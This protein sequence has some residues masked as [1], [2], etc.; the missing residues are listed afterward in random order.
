MGLLR[1]H[2][3]HFGPD[4][5][6]TAR[7]FLR[8]LDEFCQRNAIEGYRHWVT[9]HPLHSVST[10]ECDEKHLAIIRDPLRPK[11]AERVLDGPAT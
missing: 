4:A 6:E 7:H 2:W 9:E 10:L 1:F 3:D 8:H 11:R 5:P